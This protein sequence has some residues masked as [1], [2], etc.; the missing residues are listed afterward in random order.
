MS[1][2]DLDVRSLIMCLV[3]VGTVLIIR[4]S[5]ARREQRRDRVRDALD[6]LADEIMGRS[7]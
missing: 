1:D 2:S 3:V 5:E 6:V 4:Y 7:R